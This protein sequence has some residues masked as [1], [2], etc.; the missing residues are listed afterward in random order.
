MLKINDLHFRYGRR[1][2]EILRGIELEL[3]A[4]EI[5]VLLGKNGAGKTT[6]FSNI[7]G[8]ERPSSGSITLDGEQLVGMAPSKRAARIAYVPQDIS[9]GSLTVFDTVL[10]GRVAYFGLRAGADDRRAVSAI[11]DEMG[12]AE[13]AERNADALSGGE[14]QKVAIARAIAQQPKLMIFDEPTGN[15]DLAG[16]QLIAEQAKKLA[17][18][19]NIAV[20]VAIHDLNSAL[21]L[22]DR[23]FFMKDGRIAYTGG[24]DIITEELLRDIYGVDTTIVEHNGRKIILGGK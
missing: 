16:T 8:I 10:L 2:P 4:G 23:F 20:L 9:F 15:L 14:K 12:L 13:L 19:K 21:E 24:T 3:N 6:L 1:S 18:E 22:G 5:G 11:L 7:I 17:Q